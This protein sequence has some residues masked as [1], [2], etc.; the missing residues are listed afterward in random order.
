MQDSNNEIDVVASTNYPH[1]CLVSLQTVYDGNQKLNGGG[2]P[3]LAAGFPSWCWSTVP[4]VSTRNP[5][6][7][8]ACEGWYRWQWRRPVGNNKLV[9]LALPPLVLPRRKA[10]RLLTIKETPSIGFQE[11]QL[12]LLCWCDRRIW[13]THYF[14]TTSFHFCDCYEIRE[15]IKNRWML[16]PLFWIEPYWYNSPASMRL[17]IRKVELVPWQMSRSSGLHQCYMLCALASQ[18]VHAGWLYHVCVVRI[19]YHQ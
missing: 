1:V 2:N 17:K 3:L 13:Y 4:W 12:A 8:S 5:L 19:E 10:S 9:K 15:C 14:K 11:W 6:T 7:R 16:A 18:Q